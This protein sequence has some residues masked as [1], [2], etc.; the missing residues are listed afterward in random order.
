MVV[1][2]APVPSPATVMGRQLSN[3]GTVKASTLAISHSTVPATTTGHGLSSAAGR[4]G[5]WGA[6]CPLDAQHTRAT[7]PAGGLVGSVPVKALD[8]P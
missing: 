2:S 6:G 4:G 5:G 1:P 7:T 8:V 3:A